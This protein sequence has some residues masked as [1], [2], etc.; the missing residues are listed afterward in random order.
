[1][2]R[3]VAP[4]LIRP[5]ILAAVAAVLW[6]A[7]RSSVDPL[8][9]LIP[10]LKAF[11]ATTLAPSEPNRVGANSLAAPLAQSSTIFM[12]DFRWTSMPA[13]ITAALP[14]FDSQSVATV[15]E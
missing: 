13:S 10:V 11:I 9:G 12:P 2:R 1:M 5:L 6:I 15:K 4:A 3:S 8:M 14:T 7:Q